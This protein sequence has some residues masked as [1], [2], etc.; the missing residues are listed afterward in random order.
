VAVLAACLERQPDRV[1]AAYAAVER[2]GPALGVLTIAGYRAEG[3]QLQANRLGPLPGGTHR[4]EATNPVY[5]VWG[6]R[7]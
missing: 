3:T 1:V 7:P 2:V 5:L 6:E 4:L